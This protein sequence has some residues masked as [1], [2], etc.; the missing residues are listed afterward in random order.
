MGWSGHT[1]S[2]L[3]MVAPVLPIAVGT[4][5]CLYI[6]SE[7]LTGRRGRPDSPAMRP[8]HL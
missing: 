5:Y 1:V 3:T 6:C 2:M 7:Y 4:A 8:F